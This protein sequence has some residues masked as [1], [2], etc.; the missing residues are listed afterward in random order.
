MSAQILRILYEIKL[1]LKGFLTDF[2][3]NTNLIIDSKDKDS[4]NNG[5]NIGDQ[6][7]TILLK[8]PVSTVSYQAKS[9]N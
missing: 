7:G 5:D 2:R 4:N 6:W 8:H 3:S 9:F 1:Q